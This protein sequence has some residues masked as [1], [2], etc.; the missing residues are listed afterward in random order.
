MFPVMLQSVDGRKSPV[1]LIKVQPIADHEV[2]GEGE[3]DVV[4]REFRSATLGTVKQGTNAQ[5]RRT[6]ALQ[7]T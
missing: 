1:S 6:L 5:G 7:M 3:A 4:R 2:P